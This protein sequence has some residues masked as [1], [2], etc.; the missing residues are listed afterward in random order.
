[1]Q[2]TVINK[3][4]SPS[5]FFFLSRLELKLFVSHLFFNWNLMFIMN[6]ASLQAN[7]GRRLELHWY[8][9]SI[10]TCQTFPLHLAVCLNCPIPQLL[11][12][13]CLHHYCTCTWLQPHPHPGIHLQPR[14]LCMLFSSLLIL[15]LRNHLRAVISSEPGRQTCNVHFAAAINISNVSC[16]TEL[17]INC[18]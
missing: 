10:T 6:E 17:Q 11:L 16:L 2:I 14:R 4:L 1:M 12:C 7:S 5:V 18:C 9:V 3:A 8:T 15:S 13:C